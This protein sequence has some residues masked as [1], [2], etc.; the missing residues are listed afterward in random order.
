MYKFTFSFFSYALRAANIMPFSR[1]RSVGMNHFCRP[2]PVHSLQ[3]PV[4]LTASSHRLMT[5][6]RASQLVPGSS[7]RRQGNGSQG[8]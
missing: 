1:R 3:L 2:D 8:F 6:I 7:T 4:G 5:R